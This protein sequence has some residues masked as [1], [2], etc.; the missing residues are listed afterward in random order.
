LAAAR[1]IKSSGARLA[2]QSVRR[3]FGG[4]RYLLLFNLLFDLALDLG[5]R[6][7]VGFLLVFTRM[8]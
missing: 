1:L 8:M 7:E 5:E 4:M 6:L 2:E 3:H